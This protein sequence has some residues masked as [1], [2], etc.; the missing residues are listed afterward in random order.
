MRNRGICPCPRCLVP[1]A[2]FDLLG[3]FQDMRDRAAK[4][5]TY[6]LGRVTQARQFIY[7]SG[8]TVDG[9]KVQAT[10]GEGSWVPV[11]VNAF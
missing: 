2:S 11:V 5:R 10:L 7:V 3:L 8:N 6:C 9:S 1:K 4:L